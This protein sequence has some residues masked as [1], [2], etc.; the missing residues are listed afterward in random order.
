[1]MLLSLV[2]D[3]VGGLRQVAWLEA[4]SLSV[5]WKEE[6][7]AGVSSNQSS[8]Y[9]IVSESLTRKSL[10]LVNTHQL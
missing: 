4:D 8:Y 2:Q 3:M 7:S 10:Q 9:F 1:M 5:C 6:G